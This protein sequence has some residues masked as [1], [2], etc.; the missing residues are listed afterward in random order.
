MVH[1]V[2]WSDTEQCPAGG[3]VAGVGALTRGESA[4][5]DWGVDEVARAVAEGEY[6]FLVDEEGFPQLV[7][8]ER[9]ACG[10][11]TLVGDPGPREA[12][13]WTLRLMTRRSYLWEQASSEPGDDEG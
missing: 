12:S 6:F 3:H 2:V 13:R 9:C 5:R 8:T 10:A 11:P 7:T 4:P 1:Q